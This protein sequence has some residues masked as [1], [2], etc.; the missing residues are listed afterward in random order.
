MRL[1]RLTTTIEPSV[2]MIG[3]L[4]C[5]SMVAPASSESVTDSSMPAHLA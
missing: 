1:S 3:M 4:T 5:R 2:A